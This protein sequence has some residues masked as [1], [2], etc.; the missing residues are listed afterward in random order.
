MTLPWMPAKG[1]KTKRIAE[2]RMRQL[3]FHAA[4]DNDTG[5][6]HL[7]RRQI[8]EAWMTLEMDLDVAEPKQKI[9][10]Y[11]DRSVVRMFRTMGAGYQARINR[12]LATWLQ[13]KLSEYVTMEKDMLTLLS[14]AR[15]EKTRPEEEPD[16]TAGRMA[17]HEHWA[18]E[19]GYADALVGTLPPGDGEDGRRAYG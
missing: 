11:L 2:A 10:L 9:S 6:L 4:H 16:L 7:A 12:I 8:P 19:Q 3:L 1:P 14:E 5:F 13:M 18:Y 17:L 15:A